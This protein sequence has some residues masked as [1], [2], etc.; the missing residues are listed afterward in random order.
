MPNLS[1]GANLRQEW[2]FY[3]LCETGEAM[4]VKMTMSGSTVI[5]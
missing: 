3:S 2:E 4:F 5:R 1:G